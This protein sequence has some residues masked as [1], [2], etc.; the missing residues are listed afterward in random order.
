MKNAIILG[1]GQYLF[2]DYDKAK[3]IMPDHDLIAVNMSGICFPNIVHLVSLHCE[4]VP[5][6]LAVALQDNG[7]H[8]TTHSQE[9]N[10]TIPEI[11]CRWNF[12]TA[13]GSSSL[14]AVRVAL[15]LGYKRVILCGVPLDKNRRFYDG[16][17][18]K[19]EICDRATEISWQMAK[20]ELGDK[21]RSMSGKTRDILGEPTK[22]WVDGG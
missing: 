22:E 5:A 15:R 21:V 10:Q 7:R 2:G 13:G 1:S 18:R 16:Y 9:S 12:G 6:F 3:T 8:I 4:R 11:E 20:A 14:F 19:S 17:G